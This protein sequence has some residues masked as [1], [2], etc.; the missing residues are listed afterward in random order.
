MGT[1]ASAFDVRLPL[2]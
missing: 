2:I 1:R